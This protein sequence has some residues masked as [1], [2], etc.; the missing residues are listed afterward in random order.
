MANKTITKSMIIKEIS[1]GGTAKEIAGRLGISPAILRDGI[2]Q[3]NEGVEKSK[4]I[5]LRSKPKNNIAF[6]DDIE[7]TDQEEE[8][9]QEETPVRNETMITTILA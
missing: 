8:K 1:N 3:F 4:Q 2:K 9:D 5:N 6:V 7:D